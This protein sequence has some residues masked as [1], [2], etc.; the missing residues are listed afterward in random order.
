MEIANFRGEIKENEPLGRHTSFGIGGPADLLAHPIDRDDLL[1]LLAAVKARGLRYFVLGGGTN[2]LVKDGGFRGVVISLRHLE[3]IRIEREY[4]SV[5]GAFVVISAEA[6]APLARLHLFA[7]EQGLT[8]LEFA[9]GIPGSVGGAVCMNA[10]TTAGEIGDVIESVTFLSADGKL[11]VRNREEM[12]FGYRTANVPEGHLVVEAKVALRHGDKQ[13]IKARV[14]ELQEKR[15]HSQPGGFPCAGSVFKNPLEES[16]GRLIEGANLKGKRIGDAQISDKHA[17]FI[18]NVGKA[19]AKDVLALMKLI[20][21]TVLDV[22]GV[23]LEP[24]IKII[25]ED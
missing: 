1:A 3:T 2:V 5:G 13:K 14:K 8:G 19:K 6:G 15:K 9:A 21:Q 24:E 11:I 25:G 12:G 20:Q 16:A 4:R 10:G 7:A 18:V 23:R 17:N 22:H